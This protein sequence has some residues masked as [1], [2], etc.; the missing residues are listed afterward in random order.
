M[1]KTSIRNLAIAAGLT[2]A[3]ASAAVAEYPE[4][5]IR[6]IVPFAPGGG[7]DTLARMLQKVVEDNELMD[8]SLVIVNA[9]GA[10]GIVGTRQVLRAPA[11]GYTFLQVH[12]TLQAAAALGNVDVAI[13]DLIP[14][15][16]TTQ[17]CMFL[18]ASAGS[19]YTSYDDIVAAAQE[20]P[21]GIKVSDHFGGITHFFWAQIM[22]AADAEF[23]IVETGDTSRRYA[24]LK[25]NLTSAAILS[26][27][28]LNRGGEDIVPLVWLGEESPQE[29]LPTAADKGIETSGCLI[30][31]FYAK[32]GTPQE[33]IDYF[34]EVLR[35]AFETQEMIDLHERTDSEIVFL[36]GQ[37]AMD[38]MQA[39]LAS[40]RAVAPQVKAA[41][42]Q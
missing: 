30:R 41:T 3:T 5:P 24:S 1:I 12:S 31:R 4:K 42:A 39:E 32:A 27:G 37:E 40:F 28:W 16:Q 15:A 36:T 29:G 21:N 2:V 14:V 35:Q 11:D 18:A 34:A 10:G 13:D 20:N 9:P 8:Q 6:L 25:G 22:D 7:T 38:G 19:G 23:G 33:A 17:S 26:A